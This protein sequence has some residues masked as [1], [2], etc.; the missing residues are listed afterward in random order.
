M[1]FLVIRFSSIG[2]IVLTTPV[3][4]CL[5]KQLP[6]AEVHFLTKK[7][8]KAVTEHN[9]YIDKFFYFDK[10]LKELKQELKKEQ[11]DYIIDL[12]KNFRTFS[13]KLSLRRKSFTYKKESI[14]KFLL[15]KFGINMMLKKHITQRSLETIYPLGIKDDHK[16]LDYFIAEKD[17]VP[18]DAIPLTHRFGFVAI[19]IG[20]SYFTKKLPIE[21]LQELCTKIEHPI[22]LIGGGEDVWE[23][24]Q[25]EKVDTIKIYNACGK[26]N[27]N[28]SA[29]LVRKSKLVISH[30]TGLQYIACAFNKPVLAIWGGT[31]PKLDVEP[32]YG[33]AYIASH[34]K[35]TYKNFLVEGLS[36]QPC[37]NFGTRSCPKGHFKC[38]KLQDVGTIQAFTEKVLW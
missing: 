30:D 36:C 10:N 37:S 38:M 17:V 31:S 11:Y 27:L 28:Q 15:T 6:D 16:G 1:K 20:G 19:V 9:P 33:N 5:K 32:Y 14:R 34:P 22:I 26:F 21:K 23:A 4:R 8:M 25:I 35:F 7:S 3:M 29:D 12:H 24:E 13:I 18:I 2:D